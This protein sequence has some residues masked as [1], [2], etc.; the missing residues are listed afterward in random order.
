MRAFR[1]A[2]AVLLTDVIR[3]LADQRGSSLRPPE[4]NQLQ[5][6]GEA[7]SAE[8]SDAAVFATPLTLDE[9]RNKQAVLATD[10]GDIVI[11]LPRSWHRTT[12][13]T[14]SKTH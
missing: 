10:L 13:A 8:A 7:G 5:P 14:S 9:M 6:T 2:A 1:L 4:S 11:D 3:S 12:S